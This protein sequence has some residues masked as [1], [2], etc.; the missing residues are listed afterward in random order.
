MSHLERV[1]ETVGRTLL[2]SLSGFFPLLAE[3]KHL[4]I[5][6]QMPLHW[7]EPGQVLHLKPEQQ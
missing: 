4:V 3:Q 7:F 1:L 6:E 5:E 2:V